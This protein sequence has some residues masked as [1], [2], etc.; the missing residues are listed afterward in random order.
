MTFSTYGRKIAATAVLLT[1]LTCGSAFAQETCLTARSS[2]GL[3]L[4]ETRAFNRARD[5]LSSA[6]RDTEAQIRQAHA[7]NGFVAGSTR[8]GRK[9]IN[10]YRPD[11][12]RF[13]KKCD[14]YQQVCVSY[15]QTQNCPA[16]QYYSAA[17]RR[18]VTLH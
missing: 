5:R 8:F 18:C 2:S 9:S 10:C 4:G 17:A 13:V 11:P 6:L 15:T 12:Q 7:K 16:N 1:A 14:G 3:M